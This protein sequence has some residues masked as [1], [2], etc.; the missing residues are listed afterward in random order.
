MILSF[1]EWEYTKW[2]YF[3]EQPNNSVCYLVGRYDRTSYKFN[4]Q[5][6][7]FIYTHYSLYALIRNLGKGGTNNSYLYLLNYLRT[8]A[9][10]HMLNKSLL[11]YYVSAEYEE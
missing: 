7:D 6:K 11:F 9:R 5:A 8:D 3:E 4:C 10:G 1:L 2:S